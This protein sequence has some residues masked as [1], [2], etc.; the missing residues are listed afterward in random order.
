MFEIVVNTFPDPCLILFENTFAAN[1][2][3]HFV[4]LFCLLHQIEN[5]FE[6]LVSID[7]AISEQIHGSS[8]VQTNTTTT[9]DELMLGIMLEII[10]GIMFGIVVEIV[11]RCNVEFPRLNG[12]LLT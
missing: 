8:S 4:F 10:P 7:L 9:F 5:I 12:E 6:I 11:N 2:G 3:T 1:R